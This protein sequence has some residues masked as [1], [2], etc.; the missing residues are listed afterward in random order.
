VDTF[1]NGYFEVYFFSKPKEKYLVEN[2]SFSSI[3]GDMF[4]SYNTYLTKKNP[5]IHEADCS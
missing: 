4:I 1:L 5:C 3:I 2:N